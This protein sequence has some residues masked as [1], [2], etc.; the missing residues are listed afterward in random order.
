MVPHRWGQLTCH[1]EF[2]SW[3]IIGFNT[4]PFFWSEGCCKDLCELLCL[5]RH[6]CTASLWFLPSWMEHFNY[7]H[8][9]Y[10]ECVFSTLPTVT[11]SCW[12]R[13]WWSFD[14][15]DSSYLHVITFLIVFEY[16]GFVWL[17][18][19]FENNKSFTWASN[20]FLTLLI[21][22]LQLHNIFFL[23]IYLFKFNS[24]WLK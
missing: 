19:F 16:W 9:E 6:F 7:E 1:F 4:K 12:Y 17:F 24:R 13:N 8:H 18:F 15:F 22:R 2:I 11:M 21:E 14:C 23:Q 20:L 5:L 3:F 10:L